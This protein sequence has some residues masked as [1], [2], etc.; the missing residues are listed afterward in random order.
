M[1]RSLKAFDLKGKH[2]LIRVD[3][4]VPLKGEQVADNFRIQA[5]LPT[6]NYTLEE[7]AA[8]VLMSHLGRPD[9]APDPALSLMPVGEALAGLLE[10]PI[11][12]S[13]DCI[14]SDALDTS[15]S[16]KPGEIHLLENLRFHEQEKQND[17]EFSRQLARHGSVYLNDAFGTA[18]RSHASNVGVAQHFKH[19]G[20]GFL[21]EKEMQFLDKVMRSPRR[22]LTLILGGAKIDSKL[23]LIRTFLE[24]ADTILIG[25]GMSFTFLK[26]R[27]KEVGGSLVDKTMLSTAKDIINDARSKSVKLVL[28][29]DVICGENL[30]DTAPKGPFTVSSIPGD[31]M[32][33][34][35]GPKT[36]TKFL[37]ELNKSRTVIWNGPLGVFEVQGYHVGSYKIARHLAGFNEAGRIAIIG[38]GDTAAAVNKF[39]LTDKMSHV[40]T[41]GGASLELL[42]GKR[43]PALESLEA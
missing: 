31:L 11:K 3:F 2:V 6:I 20:M 19:R 5:A 27:G 30:D 36:I 15:L 1:I 23:A 42:S 21:V 24:K 37:D 16:L 25:G 29:E 13:H 10:M 22:P 18:H 35:I 26:A 28:P 43:L 40:S 39:K 8:L 7:G 12:F 38:G 14:T 41:G 17:P 34:D 4:N 33:L 32:G 9:G